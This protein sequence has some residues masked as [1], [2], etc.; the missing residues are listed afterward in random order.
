MSKDIVSKQTK[1]KTMERK[2]EQKQNDFERMN[3]M[4]FK[5]M[6]TKL[7]GNH[8][9]ELDK[10]ETEFQAAYQELHT[11]QRE[12]ESLKNALQLLKAKCESLEESKMVANSMIRRLRQIESVIFDGPTPSHPSEGLLVQ[13]TKSTQHQ[14]ENFRSILNRHRIAHSYLN[15][16][17]THCRKAIKRL[18]R[19]KE[20]ASADLVF[21]AII[22]DGVKHGSIDK[23]Q[24][25]IKLCKERVEVAWTIYP[26]LKNYFPEGTI[27]TDITQP[28]LI[29]D[30]L[31][32]NIFTDY[33]IRQKI[34]KSLKT[35]ETALHLLIECKT[36]M[37][38]SLEVLTRNLSQAESLHDDALKQLKD[39]RKDII[40]DLI[41][42][43]KTGDIVDATANQQLLD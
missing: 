23:A 37:E 2:I 25:D 6:K 16:A 21:D 29:A 22:L 10:R 26:E 14:I 35:A 36:N 17:V 13:Q 33:H 9:Q 28:N 27:S 11:E 30:V 43:K 40:L 8:K 39:V 4:T 3:S 34:K 41:K 5:S 7:V 18:H 38:S 15:D 31:F 19:A 12:L 20:F 1:I 32:D 24:R 42:S